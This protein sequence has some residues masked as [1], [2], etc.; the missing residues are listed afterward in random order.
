MSE[1]AQRVAARR[2][3]LTHDVVSRALPL[4]SPYAI[5]DDKV[6]GF[7][8]RV[9][10]GGTKSF[11]VQ[12][13]TGAGRR[14]D[15]NRKIT[16]GRF[17]PMAPADARKRAQALIGSVRDGGD[18]AQERARARALP[19]LGE[20]AE[21]WLR[22]KAPHLAPRS[23][24]KYRHALRIVLNGWHTRRLDCLM[25]ENVASRFE[26]MTRAH[27]RSSANEGVKVL[28]ALYRRATVDHPDLRDPVARWKNAGGR[29]HRIERRRIDP[30]SEVLPTW[31]RGIERA[32]RRPELRDLFWFGMYTG[33]R[34][35]EV[36][37]LRWERVDANARAF[38]VD[39]TKTGEPL[40]LPITRQLD[41]V[42]VRRWDA[43]GCEQ[44]GPGSPWVF[45]TPEYPEHRLRTPH[46]H[47]A[48]ISKEAGKKFWFHALRN[49]FITVALHDMNLPESLVKRLVNHAPLTDVTQGYAAQWTLDQLRG[50]AQRIADRIDTL[51]AARHGAE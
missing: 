9:S 12:C 41:R 49:A 20:A 24:S 1:R 11:F 38:R 25:R 32:V 28:A 2:A 40:V 37:S 22:I 36:Q 17:P 35:G 10:P 33:M 23:L 7:G 45:T 31:A 42:L 14:T 48:G 26:S 19:T 44:R 13:C 51:V 27:G 3:T 6:T 46:E 4:R 29:L 8:L 16:L 34:L 30:P 43:T 15:K 39:E 5:W 50:P 47:Y 18:P 21:D